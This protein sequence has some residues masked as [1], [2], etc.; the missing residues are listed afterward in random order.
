MGNLSIVFF[1]LSA[2]NAGK[3][4]KKLLAAFRKLKITYPRDQI[5][6]HFL[7][8]DDPF[9]QFPTF[10]AE[11]F[12]KVCRKSF[13]W[14]QKIVLKEKKH[15]SKEVFCLWILDLEQKSFRIPPKKS[16]RMP[17]FCSISP[18]EHFEENNVEKKKIFLFR[19]QTLIE[20]RWEVAQKNFG[21][22]L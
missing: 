16:A 1:R 18:K 9:C 20:K 3:L 17:N 19:F 5:L 6:S 13:P 11:I 12:W 21:R 2:K 14:R 8:F 4:P 22:V 10:L 7:M 15:S